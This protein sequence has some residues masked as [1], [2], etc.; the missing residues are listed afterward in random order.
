[1]NEI[2]VLEAG[3]RRTEQRLA[4]YE[5]KYGIDT[6]EFIHRFE[7]NKFDETLDFIEWIGEYRMLQ[8][9]QEERRAV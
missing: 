8:A 4:E 5:E 2:D 6:H 9:L 1:M 3:I 7:T